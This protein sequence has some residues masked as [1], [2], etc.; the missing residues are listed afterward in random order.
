MAPQT[1]TELA[2][3]K[4]WSEVLGL[5]R[6]GRHDNFFELGGHS[7]RPRA[8]RR[9]SRKRL[10]RPVPLAVLFRADDRGPGAA[11]RISAGKLRGRA[12]FPASR[13]DGMSPLS[14]AQQRLWFL[15]QFEPQQCDVQHSTGLSPPRTARRRAPGGVP[16]RSGAAARGVTDDVSAPRRTTGSSTSAPRHLGRLAVTD[17]SD[18]PPAER[19]E[20]IRRRLAAEAQQPFDLSQDLMLRAGL[21][22]LDEQEHIFWLTSITLR[23]DG[24][25]VGILH[26]ELS[27]LYAAFARGQP[28]PLAELPIQYVDFAAWQREWL[29]GEVLAEQLSY[30]KRQLAGAPPVLELPT[31][32]P[33]PAT[34][35]YRGAQQC[36]VFDPQLLP[37]LEQLSRQEGVTLFM[38]LLAAFQTLLYRYSGQEDIVVGTPIAGRQRLETE[39]LIGLF[40]NTLVL[41]TDLSGNPTFRE[42]LGRVRE[43]TL[44]AYAHQDLPFEKLVEEL[45]PQ[46]NLSYAPLFQVMLVLQNAP[47]IPLSPTGA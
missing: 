28:S 3:A 12:R 24:W 7:L 38:T 30:W 15:D 29:Q 25:S 5:E 11:A 35:T 21:L 6:V 31:D 18:L 47:Q 9:E 44:G 10:A 22:R 36:W 1:P 46:R 33:R 39:E 43:V 2:I 20:E 17:L 34:Q 40:V 32:R 23:R 27:A 19:D 37:A 41:R 8:C 14:F 26:R 42:L 45:N 13:G 4:I 16:W